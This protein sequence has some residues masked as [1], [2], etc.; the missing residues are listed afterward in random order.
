MVP[1]TGF[2]QINKD[3]LLGKW[4][5]DKF[6]ILKTKEFQKYPYPSSSRRKVTDW[7]RIEGKSVKKEFW[8]R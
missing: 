1:W 5:I 8:R 4:V 3:F 2:I 6:R 7:V